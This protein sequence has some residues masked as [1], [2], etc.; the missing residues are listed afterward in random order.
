MDKKK[1]NYILTCL[2]EYHELNNSDIKEISLDM[3][4]LTVSAGVCL[5]GCD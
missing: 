3:Q 5:I 4:H 1:F 2:I